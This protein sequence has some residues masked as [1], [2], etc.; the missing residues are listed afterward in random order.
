VNYRGFISPEIGH[1]S[2]DA[3]QLTKVSAALD[4]ILAM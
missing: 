4:R 2:S 1:D 3:G